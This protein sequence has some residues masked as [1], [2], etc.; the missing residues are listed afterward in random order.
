LRLEREFF[1]FLL[2]Y[3][4]NT[5]GDPQNLIHRLA[6]DVEQYEKAAKKAEEQRDFVRTLDAQIDKKEAELEIFLRKYGFTGE[7][8]IRLLYEDAPYYYVG[9]IGQNGKTTAFL[10]NGKTGKLLAKRER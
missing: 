1:A 9:V 6:G 10:L 7:I 5:D 4:A 8:C 2:Q 3:G